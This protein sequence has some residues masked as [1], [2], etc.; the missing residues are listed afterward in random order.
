MAANC[1]E[2]PENKTVAARVFLVFW[3]LSAKPLERA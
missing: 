1:F 2:V 3:S